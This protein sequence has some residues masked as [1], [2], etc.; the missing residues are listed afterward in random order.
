M[1]EKIHSDLVNPISDTLKATKQFDS[2]VGITEGSLAVTAGIHK[3]SRVDILLMK[4]AG[5]GGLFL[6]IKVHSQIRPALHR[7]SDV[8]VKGNSKSEM[9]AKCELTAAVIAEQLCLV[10]KDQI[11]PSECARMAGKH[12]DELCRELERSKGQSSV[13]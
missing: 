8:A 2:D 9:R 7:F 3:E 6:R 10:Y 1:S 13:N 5:D 4:R 12:Y 11:D